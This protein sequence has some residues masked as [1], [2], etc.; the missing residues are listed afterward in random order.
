M[1]PASA[2]EISSSL[3]QNTDDIKVNQANLAEDKNRILES[4]DTV[5]YHAKIIQDTVNQ[6]NQVKWYQF[7]K[8]DFYLRQGPKKINDEGKIIE[9]LSQNINKT[10]SNAKI[11]A[12]QAMDNGEKGIQIALN[13]TNQFNNSDFDNNYNTGNANQNAQIIADSLS[14][15]FK[16]KYRVTG[17]G[18]LEKGDIVQVSMSHNN[19]VYL[20]YVGMNPSNDTALFIGEQIQPSDCLQII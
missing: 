11:N 1:I 18:T 13:N 16:N 20:E 5:D 19:Y 15:H 12:N 6:M 8:W 2:V 3:E 14:A 4:A 9:S 7:W 10:G 17:T